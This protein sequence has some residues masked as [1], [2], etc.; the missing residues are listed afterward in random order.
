VLDS[1]RR[2]SFR[3]KRDRRAQP[4]QSYPHLMN[5]FRIAIADGIGVS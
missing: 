3:K 4:A 1:Y 5:G 2:Q